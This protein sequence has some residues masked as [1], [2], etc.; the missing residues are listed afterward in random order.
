MI[1]LIEKIYNNHKGR[2]VYRRITLVLNNEGIN[3]NHKKVLR[4]I[5]KFGLKGLMRNK[6]KYS[7]YKGRIGKI[8]DNIIK[9]NFEADRANFKWFTDIT[10]F[11]LKGEKLYL[12]PILMIVEDI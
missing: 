3:I 6:R 5:K 1:N 11:N 9:R 8:A 7:S 2:Y 12:S 10:E 4:I